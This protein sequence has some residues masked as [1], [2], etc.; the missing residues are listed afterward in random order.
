M[1]SAAIR[2]VPATAMNNKARR[3]MISKLINNR[4]FNNVGNIFKKL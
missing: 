3:S 1:I 2:V 4:Y